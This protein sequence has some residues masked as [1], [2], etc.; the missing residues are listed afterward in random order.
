MQQMQDRVT[1]ILSRVEE[2]T[3]K[4]AL[5]MQGLLAN[6][7]KAEVNQAK[8]SLNLQSVMQAKEREIV[9]ETMAAYAN[10]LV[11]G[12]NA[13]KRA[14]EL[15][16]ALTEVNVKYD[17]LILQAREKLL[18]AEVTSK[19]AWAS[20]TAYQDVVRYRTAAISKG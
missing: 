14:A 16:A 10:G 18:L 4:T 13:E 15:G 11:T 8:A 9:A 7:E 1:G 17:D 6:I 12:S 19:V 5:Y 3:S 20:L 2:A